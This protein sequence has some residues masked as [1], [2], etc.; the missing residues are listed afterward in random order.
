MR[1]IRNLSFVLLLCAAPLHAQT[2]GGAGPGSRR[3]TTPAPAANPAPAR[4]AGLTLKEVRDA[5]AK[6]DVD[7]SGALSAVEAA[8]GGLDASA[9]AAG[10]ADS[11][12]SLS[13][14]EY[15]VTSESRAVRQPAGAANDL[16][17]ESTRLQAVRRAQKS[18]ELKSKREVA[19]PPVPAPAGAAEKTRAGTPVPAAPMTPAA[20]GPAAARR[21]LAPAAAT[22]TD[23]TRS[24]EEV[25]A[26]IL[27]RVRN[28][29]ISADQARQELEIVDQRLAKTAAAN[30]VPNPSVVAPATTPAA[31]G[32]ESALGAA[33]DPSLRS[34]EESLN[35]RLR[36]SELDS[37]KAKELY[38][39]TI[40]RIENAR[41]TGTPQ[42]APGGEAKPQDTATGKPAANAAPTDP[43]GFRSKIVE[44]QG[45]LTRRLR[46]AELTPEQ[47]ALEQASMTRRLRQAAESLKTG[48]TAGASGTADS[49]SAGAAPAAAGS[50]TAS[51]TSSNGATPTTGS[52]TTDAQ[53]APVP[54][55]ARTRRAGPAQPAPAANPPA[56]RGG[57]ATP[58]APA[59]GSS[60]SPSPAPNPAPATRPPVARPPTP[61]PAD[62]PADGAAPA[63]PALGGN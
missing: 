52:A 31:G 61:P 10:D 17:A 15:T 5:F 43:Q 27:R 20:G 14:D 19:T 36:N 40:R 59:R 8:A 22:S 56:R 3:A 41:G 13:L 4:P 58:A 46:N 6:A 32:T 24:P 57:D 18:E 30:G 47:A 26:D 11:D 37:G 34:I 1:P 63:R 51:D 38:G 45:D 35:R 33:K 49:S 2:T 48:G 42:P 29:E 53:P 39:D 50:R 60:T 21:A 62:K 9:F 44:A 7:R 55:P 54:A 16:T 28:A 12:A 23:S 25:R